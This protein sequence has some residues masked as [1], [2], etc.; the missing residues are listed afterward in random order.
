MRVAPVA[1]DRT[2]TVT[3][4]PDGVWRIALSTRIITS[5]RSRAGSPVTTAGCGSTAIATP[6]SAA[7]LASADAPSA[8][9]SPRSTGTRSSATAPESERASS[10]RSS[11]IAVMWRTSASMSSSADADLADR[12]VLVAVEVLDAAA[13]DRE[14][15]PELVAGVGREV[16]LAA[17]RGPL[18]RQRLADRD[19]RPAGVDG[20]EAERDQDDHD[21]ADQQHDQHRLERP[22]LG[23][24]VLDDLDR[25]DLALPR[26]DR[27]GQDPDRDGIR[28]DGR[29]AQ[30]RAG[31]PGSGDRVVV[32]Q[33]R[34]HPEVAGPGDDMVV[35][36]DRERERRRS[37]LELVRARCRPDPAAG[38]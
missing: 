10:S 32:G 12:L 22:D 2:A 13:H 20:P 29:S 30:V 24:A 19:E 16:A 28:A 5:W 7:G 3:W 35:L 27:L 17:K 25:D 23:G 34:R 8:A 21:P 9:T 1:S 37:E 15:G 18:V 6:P 4:P 14:R 11:T 31:R 38:R 36:V 33:A 26:G